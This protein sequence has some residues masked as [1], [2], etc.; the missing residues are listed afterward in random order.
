MSAGTEVVLVSMPWLNS[1]YPSVSLGI[2]HSVLDAAGVPCVTRSYHL[3]FAEHLVTAT[4]ADPRPLT[5]DDYEWI[6]ERGRKGIGDWAF[7]VPPYAEPDPTRDEGF[8]RSAELGLTAEEIERCWRVRRL[9]PDF[10]RHCARDLR[11]MSP[12]VVGFTSTFCQNVSSLVLARML[13]EQDPGLVV[14]LGGSNC[15]GPMGAALHRNFPWIDVVVRGEAEQVLPRLVEDILSGAEPR[16]QPGLCLRRDGRSIAVPETAGTVA[17]RDVPAPNYDDY[18]AD[19]AVSP[20]GDELRIRTQIPYES[21]RGCW[22][23]AKH[24]CTFCGLNGATMRFRS[25]PAEQ[26]MRELRDLSVRYRRLDFQVVDNILDM[27]YFD[28]LLPGLARAGWDL[29]LFFETKSNLR[30]DQVRRL[31]AAGVRTIQPGIE[32]LSSPILALMRKGVTAL[33]NVRLL[34]WC[35]AYG[36]SV[37]WNMIYGFPG[38]PP[39]EYVHM[40][41]DIAALVHLEPPDLVRLGIDRFSPYHEEAAAL[42][43]RVLGPKR[44]YRALYDVDPASLE[45]LAY[46][47][48]VAHLDGRDPDAY[49]SPTKQ[50]IERWRSVRKEAALTCRVGPDFLV[51]DDQR[52]GL[53]ARYVLDRAEAEIYLACDAGATVSG[54]LRSLPEEISAALEV[55]DVQGLVD[56]LTT[57]KLLY[58]EGERY[59]AL[60]VPENPVTYFERLG[61][62]SLATADPPQERLTSTRAGQAGSLRVVT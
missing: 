44:F 50:A 49:I 34:K 60:A 53:A 14:V 57:S 4:R 26:V 1:Y 32:S 39:D 15:E 42:G 41:A 33:Q 18:Y 46:F 25:K 11:A 36:I 10:L 7:V 61:R 29:R 47:F 48:E 56:D 37:A 6:A 43:L 40:A 8:L 2:L 5:V 13:K 35:A 45:E 9:V 12:R 19:L 54:I 30:V 17:M 16:P 58:R 22:W 27:T 52:P 62:Q 28:T 23:G 31:R 38:E 51:I 21:A 20:V 59:L 24:H 55:D 3:G